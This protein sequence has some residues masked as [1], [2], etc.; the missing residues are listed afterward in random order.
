MP[1]GDKAETLYRS[2]RITHWD[3][4]AR[5][6]DRRPGLGRYYRARHSHER[7]RVILNTYNRRWELPIALAARLGLARPTLAQN[8]LTVEDLSHLLRLTRFEVVRR[9]EEALLPLPIPLLAPLANR[10]LVR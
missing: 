2:R 3:E 4:V 10:F 6:S 7:T 5:R 8:W 9:S 1:A